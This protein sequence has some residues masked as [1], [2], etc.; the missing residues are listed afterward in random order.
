MA[1]SVVMPAL[2]MAQES[3]K[4]ISWLKKEGDSIAKGEP[5]AEI[6]TDK[7][8][9]ELEAPGEGVLAGVKS[10]AGEVVPVGQVIAWIVAP[11]EKPPADGQTAAPAARAMTEK[12]P[13][14]AAVAA[15]PSA[16][17]APEP[18][19]RV[20]PKARRMAKELGVDLSRVTG[21]GPS[22]II[23]GEDVERAA[24]A[25]KG[26]PAPSASA[27]V[28]IPPAP[29]VH[30]PPSSELSTIA[31]LM[32]ERTTQSWTTAPHFFL[33]REIDASGLNQAREKF[34][35]PTT[36]TD[37]LVAL[38]AR[39]LARHPKM[40]A[41]WDGKAIHYSPNVNISI[42]IAVKDGVIG[43]VIPNADKAS[44]AEITAKRQDLAERARAG[45]LHP[46]DI[47]GGTFTISNLGMFGVDAF[48]AI[49]TPPQAAVLAVGRITDR[50]VPV[51]GLIGIRPIMTMTLSS[52]HR[53]VDGAQAAVFL[54]DLAEA[55][56]DPLTLRG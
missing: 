9:L 42:A 5:L 13:A 8:V 41:S 40:N 49:I 2:E 17:K 54:N 31:R 32:A 16:A 43:A 19:P 34:G 6:E 21:T 10:G 20:S 15:P 37:L 22:G 56:T 7:V 27:P 53:V 51:H 11:G 52:D 4:I 12:R 23:S 18:E 48:S 29:A 55:L 47:T 35:K 30:I 50:V 26:A 33:V 14:P 46:P 25:Q 45:R 36:H 44:I 3:G 1:V 39:T 38:V 24:A 28:A